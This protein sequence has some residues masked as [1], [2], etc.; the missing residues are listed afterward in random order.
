MLG[1]FEYLILTAAANLGDG[2]YGTAILEEIRTT[3]GQRRSIGALYTTM[4]RLEAKG[5][6]TT[7]MGGATLERGGRAKRLARVTP[8]GIQAARAFYQAMIRVSRRASWAV[9]EPGST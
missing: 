8:K 3:T 4:K 9:P 2:A 1:E 7:W 5:L 6:L